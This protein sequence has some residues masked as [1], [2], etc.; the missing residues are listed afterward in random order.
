MKCN[1]ELNVYLDVQDKVSERLNSKVLDNDNIYIPYTNSNKL[2]IREQ[3]KKNIK[4]IHDKYGTKSGNLVS[5]LDGHQFGLEVEIHIP[6]K[7]YEEVRVKNQVFN[8][9]ESA[10]EQQKK[11]A[12]RAGVEYTD[13]YLY[14]EILNVTPT[15]NTPEAYDYGLM[16]DNKIEYKNYLSNRINILKEVPNQTKEIKR[17]IA[18]LKSAVKSLSNDIR[19]LNKV[20]NVLENFLLTSIKI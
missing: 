11:D 8:E 13:D 2:A 1:I 20:D 6:E 12:K 19:E 5:I 10:R 3:V 16:L 18:Q 15:P 4:D 9:V 14:S 7:V 17:Q